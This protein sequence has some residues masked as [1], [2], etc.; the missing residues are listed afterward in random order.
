M[1]DL[2]HRDLEDGLRR[3]AQSK[4]GDQP[5]VCHTVDGMLREPAVEEAKATENQDPLSVELLLTFQHLLCHNICCY[6]FTGGNRDA[7]GERMTLADIIQP[8]HPLRHEIFVDR[9]FH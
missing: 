7:E 2:I 9:T 4:G 1:K 5:R 6:G 3:L 8:P